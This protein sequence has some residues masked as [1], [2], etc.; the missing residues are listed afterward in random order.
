VLHAW[1]IRAN[2]KKV[3]VPRN[4]S[5]EKSGMFQLSLIAGFVTVFFFSTWCGIAHEY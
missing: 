4:K 3:M 5:V 1:V 2:F